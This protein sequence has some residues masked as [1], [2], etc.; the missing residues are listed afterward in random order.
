MAVGCV[1][2]FVAAII[3][4]VPQLKEYL[5]FIAS[6]M[7]IYYDQLISFLDNTFS[8]VDFVQYKSEIAS[9]KSEIQKFLAQKI[10]I[11]ASIVGEI[12]SKTEIISRFFSFCVVMPISFF[13]F[14]KDWKKMV[15]YVYSCIPHRQK[16]MVL[17]T[18]NV[19]RR[20]F[21]SFVHGQ[22]YVVAALSAYYTIMLSVIGLHNEAF[23]GLLSGLLSF[24]P[25]IGALFSCTVVIFANV[26]ILTL[27]KLYL[28]LGIYAAGQFIEGYILS[29][30]FVGKRTGLHPLWILFSFFAG[31]QLGG[32][33]G[34]LIAIPLT[35]IINNLMQLALQKFKASQIYKQ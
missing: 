1:C 14:L 2:I 12:A 34:V 20:T 6:N 21:S 15:D 23:L 27:T 5:V 17:E 30:K 9:L 24:I 18:S 16:R 25:L 7:P 28:I 13:Y 35:A 29:P 33:V 22:F 19:I 11:L 3:E 4:I 31:I 26:P 32:V 10:Y 8:S